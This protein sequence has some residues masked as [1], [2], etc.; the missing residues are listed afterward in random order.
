MVSTALYL[1]SK[2]NVDKC[3]C[4]NQ[5]ANAS[6][7][8]FGGYSSVEAYPAEIPPIVA[9]K[10]MAIVLLKSKILKTIKALVS[11]LIGKELAV[12]KGEALDVEGV[13]RADMEGGEDVEGEEGVMDVEGILGMEG[14][15]HKKGGEGM[16]AKRKV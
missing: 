2:K 7:A 5:V 10:S 11:L 8:A 12:L 1:S 6:C 15:A 9:L 14:R 13:I 16:I 4:I 3:Y